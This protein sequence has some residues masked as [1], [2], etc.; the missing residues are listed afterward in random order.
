MEVSRAATTAKWAATGRL[1]APLFPLE[2]E[3]PAPVVKL[4]VSHLHFCA[5]TGL[6]ASACEEG[7]EVSRAATTAKWAA[8]AKPCVRPF[9]TG[10]VRPA[11]TAKSFVSLRHLSPARVFRRPNVSEAVTGAPHVATTA[12]WAA[13]GKLFAPRAPMALVRRRET[14]RSRVSRC[15]PLLARISC[16]GVHAAVR[17]AHESSPRFCDRRD[18][19]R[20][21]QFSIHK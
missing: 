11:G 12:K 1:R 14:V 3:W 18:T 17:C 19:R 2:R 4:P 9:P 5:R 16:G 21:V 13:T 10:P 6:R 7:M 8:M 15:A 20:S